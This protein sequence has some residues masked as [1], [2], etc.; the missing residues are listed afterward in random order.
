M[1]KLSHQIIALSGPDHLVK[2]L[3][4]LGFVES[5]ILMIQ[6]KLPFGGPY[7]VALKMHSSP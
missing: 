6:S 5:E 1:K 3:V 2:R 7:V 4:E